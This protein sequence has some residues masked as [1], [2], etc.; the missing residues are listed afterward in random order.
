MTV[1]WRQLGLV[2][3]SPATVRDVWARK[4]LGSFATSYTVPH[5]PAGGV[6]MLTVSGSDMPATTGHQG[7]A[8]DDAAWASCPACVNGKTMTGPGLAIFSNVA[9]KASGGFIRIAYINDSDRTTWAQL[10]TNGGRPTTLAFPPTGS[11]GSIGTITAFALFQSGPN[12]LALSRVD[13]S[14]PAPAIGYMETVAGPVPLS[15]PMQ[16]KRPKP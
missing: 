10:K 6:V 4:D 12:T 9:S 14:T 5:V 15:L 3:S 16:R 13:S 7:A 1:T 11:D 8:A 2:P